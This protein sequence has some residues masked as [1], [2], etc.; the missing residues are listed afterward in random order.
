MLGFL[1]K[2]LAYACYRRAQVR[3]SRAKRHKDA[4]FR[5]DPFVRLILDRCPELKNEARV[6]CIGARNDVEIRILE[7]YGFRDITAIDLWSSSP[8]IRV[9]DM[10]ALDFPDETFD[11][12]FASHA[13][14]H[15]FDFD[16]VAAEVV[17]VL[18]EPGYVFCAVPVN[19][20]LSEHDRVDFKDLNGLLAAFARSSV[21]PLYSRL[22]NGELSAL[23]RIHKGSR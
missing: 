16:R 13:F 20:E 9:M 19:Y 18:R 2:R 5:L 22:H 23:L 7:R 3:Q 10:H 14:E 1:R 6:L 17:R 4:S 8:R 15:A 11:L 21:E 12:V